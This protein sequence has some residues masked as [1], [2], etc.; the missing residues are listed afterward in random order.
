[1]DNYF[2]NTHKGG[3]DHQL[4]TMGCS[5]I[6]T[7]SAHGTFSIFGMYVQTEANG[8]KSGI[9]VAFSTCSGRSS[10]SFSVGFNIAGVRFVASKIPTPMTQAMAE[11]LE[12][13]EGE[14]AF[15]FSPQAEFV[16][17]T[18]YWDGKK[19][20]STFEFHAHLYFSMQLQFSVYEMMKKIFPAGLLKHIHKYKKALT[21]FVQFQAELIV[22]LHLPEFDK[23]NYFKKE[24]KKSSTDPNLLNKAFEEALKTTALLKVF[25]TLKIDFT[26]FLDNFP[27]WQLL[28]PTPDAKFELN[29]DLLIKDG[30]FFTMEVGAS[31][32]QDMCNKFLNAFSWL[33]SCPT[34]EIKAHIAFW[35]S[36]SELGI[37]IGTTYNGLRCRIVFGGK[38]KGVHCDTFKN[39]QMKSFSGV[40]G[41]AHRLRQMDT[42]L[43]HNDVHLYNWLETNDEHD[44]NGKLIR[45]GDKVR[46]GEVGQE[47]RNGY[48]VGATRLWSDIDVSK[49][50]K[51]EKESD[52]DWCDFKFKGTLEVKEKGA[53][54]ETLH[55]VPIGGKDHES[56]SGIIFDKKIKKIQWRCRDENQEKKG[57][58]H[59][60]N[61][62][63][64]RHSHQRVAIQYNKEM[65]QEHPLVPSWGLTGRIYFHG[66]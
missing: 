48:L 25:G 23:I 22:M 19:H 42:E 12:L 63:E 5:R 45:V 30:I 3:A 61:T 4:Q 28:I 51:W 33:W 36:H 15:G 24:S 60:W 18:T 49:I 13:V 1:M 54:D 62:R 8:S 9:C 21:N 38:K 17:Q 43:Q 52:W 57:N 11:G 47:M 41:A 16:V 59:H 56:W 20:P 50:S 34:F 53:P 35:L 31:V 40:L 32:L 64:F 58:I 55:P 26:Y 2:F 44:L 39:D 6:L 29:A 14:V 7:P 10:F 27:F 46:A 37:Q 66:F 65:K